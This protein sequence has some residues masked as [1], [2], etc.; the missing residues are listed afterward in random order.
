MRK[1]RR[2]FP[3]ES[4]R[5]V[6]LENVQDT[7]GTTDDPIAESL[8]KRQRSAEYEKV[9]PPFGVAEKRGIAAIWHDLMPFLKVAGAIISFFVAVVLPIV[10]YASKLDSNVDTLK[11]DV[12]DVKQRTEEL[13]NNSVQH[14]ERLDGLE[15]S[16]VNIN[17]ELK[18]GSAKK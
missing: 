13:A 16:I 17:T 15:K 2:P 14:D 10:W 4:G 12:R 18:R 7:T 5:R 6:V 1:R 9:D 11:T 8:A 3:Y